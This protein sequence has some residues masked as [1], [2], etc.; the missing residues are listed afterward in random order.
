MLERATVAE[1]LPLFDVYLFRW[2]MGGGLALPL[3]P[4]EQV[5]SDGPRETPQEP[6]HSPQMKF[7]PIY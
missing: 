6:F 7:P 4:H 3:Y 2:L 5:T 1:F